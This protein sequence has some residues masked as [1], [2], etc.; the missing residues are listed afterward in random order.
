MPLKISA[1]KAALIYFILGLVICGLVY[2]PSLSFSFIDD[3]FCQL[4]YYSR[5]LPLPALFNPFE[6]FS[7][8]QI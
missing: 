7:D 4:G 1:S 6:H 2:G 3:D 8:Q 5:A